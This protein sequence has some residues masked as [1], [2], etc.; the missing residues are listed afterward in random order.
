MSTKG[1]F[2]FLLVM[3]I[4]CFGSLK[5]QNRKAWSAGKKNKPTDIRFK[6]N[7]KMAVICPIFQLSEFPYQGIGIKLGDPF[8]VTYKFYASEKWAVGIDGGVAAWGLYNDLWVERFTQNPDNEGLTYVSNEIDSHI[9]VAAKVARYS[10]IRGIKGLSVYYGL[11]FQTQFVTVTYDV[12]FEEPTQPGF[13]PV[14]RIGQ[15][16][17][18][19][20][21]YGPEID[22]GLEYAYFDLP[23]TTF[24]EFDM[25]F[26][27]EQEQPW[28]RFQ[29]G[30]GI[31]YVF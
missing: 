10:N 31:R 7:R 18:S 25:F 8:A 23:L 27:L 16:T 3:L 2:A 21:P 9:T 14:S 6:K 24:L 19:Y 17:E 1:F 26:N 30:I 29:G 20:Q 4:F 22:L 28:K 15:V 12:T 13:P 11:G 5:A